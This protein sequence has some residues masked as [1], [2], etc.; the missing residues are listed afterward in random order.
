MLGLSVAAA[1]GVAALSATSSV[2]DYPSMSAAQRAAFDPLAN[3]FIGLLLSQLIVAAVGVIAITGEYSSGHIR[4]TFTAMPHRGAVLAAKAAVTGGAGLLTGA[5][6]APACIV[7]SHVI[8]SGQH[9]ARPYTDPAVIR[10]TVGAAVYLSA[11][12]LTGL[13]LGVLLRHAAPAITLLVAILFIAPELLHNSSGALSYMADALP[14]TAFRQL[15]TSLPASGPGTLTTP[16]AFAVII[17]YPLILL[18]VAALTL[19]R[20]DA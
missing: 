3:A 15:A 12:A 7:V 13:A 20:R 2:K 17:A 14:G 19:R 11:V 1:A 16:A 18:A 6:T 9:L 5:L 4:T 8:L 10:A